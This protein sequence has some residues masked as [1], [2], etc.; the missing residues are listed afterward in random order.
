MKEEKLY[1]MGTEQAGRCLVKIWKTGELQIQYNEFQE[2]LEK[3][4][5]CTIVRKA[6]YIDNQKVI[7]EFIC[8]NKYYVGLANQ[9]GKEH[10]C[11]FYVDDI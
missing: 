2:L 6:I 10:H 5:E 8:D 4:K 9:F 3:I 7:L 11:E 1:Y